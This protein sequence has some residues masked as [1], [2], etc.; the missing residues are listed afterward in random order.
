M[1]KTGKYE[2]GIQNK[3]N[4]LCR[5]VMVE[6]P[7][8]EWRHESL[9]HSL[10]EDNDT[11]RSDALQKYRDFLIMR[12]ERNQMRDILKRVKATIPYD[13]AIGIHRDIEEILGV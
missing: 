8:G 9:V 2:P 11:L 7:T 4:C 3:P 6:S 12:N 10:E 13:Q 1:I 5:P